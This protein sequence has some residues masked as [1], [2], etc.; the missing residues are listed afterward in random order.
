MCERVSQKSE[1]GSKSERGNEIERS[2]C[3]SEKEECYLLLVVQAWAVW[4]GGGGVLGDGG[5]E[6]AAGAC[7]IG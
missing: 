6:L 4:G 5:G 3:V 2:E 1:K 7:P